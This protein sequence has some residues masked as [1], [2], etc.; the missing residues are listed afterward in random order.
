MMTTVTIFMNMNMMMIPMMKN[1]SVSMN[2]NKEGCDNYDNN[3]DD[4]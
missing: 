4:D 2:D 3:D 1:A